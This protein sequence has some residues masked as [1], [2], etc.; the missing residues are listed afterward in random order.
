MN[1]Y[2]QPFSLGQVLGQGENILNARHAR[3]PNNLR[4][5]L[6]AAQI[7]SEQAKASSP[8]G[9]YDPTAQMK[10]DIYR[11]QLI[12]QGASPED[13][14]RFDNWVARQQVID[15]NQVPTVVQGLTTTPLSNLDSELSA[16]GRMSGTQAFTKQTGTQAAR[17]GAADPYAPVTADE[18]NLSV[19]QASVP[20]EAELAASKTKAQEKAKTEAERESPDFQNKQAIREADAT[21][22]RAIVKE[23]LTPRKDGGGIY[24]TYAYGRANV[25]APEL[26][27]KQ[28]WIDAEAKRDQLVSMLQLENV[29]KLKGTGPITEPEQ[30]VLRQAMTVL[31]NP[32]ISPKL[33]ERELR[34]VNAMFAKWER[35][36]KAAQGKA[37]EEND[38]PLGIR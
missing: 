33:V 37:T 31:Q 25:M 15:V 24:A 14:A 17:G 8:F 11:N 13:I 10:N 2:L 4:N 30:Q 22:A 23:M 5:Q 35:D 1:N 9:G 18:I 26:M 21:N 38:D 7:G 34:R 16:A 32:L 28:E 12:N 19:N 29:S 6:L 27:K 3:D 36:A 20:S